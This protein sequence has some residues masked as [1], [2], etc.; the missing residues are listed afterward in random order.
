MRKLTK[1]WLILFVILITGNLF[2]SASSNIKVSIVPDV[3]EVV[4]G[5]EFNLKLNIK[6]PT[7]TNI[8]TFRLIVNF[9]A[10]KLEFSNIKSSYSLNDFKEYEDKGKLTIIYLTSEK[11]VNISANKLTTF[12]SLNFTAL[13][14]AELGNTKISAAIDGIGNYDV[15]EILADKISDATIKIVDKLNSN[16]TTTPTT[17]NPIINCNLKSIY[18]Q[19]YTIT[20]A[21]DPNITQY[22]VTVPSTVSSL[23]V[24]AVAED[25]SATV[26]VS[27]KKLYAAG[28]STD[29]NITVTGSDKKTKKIYKLT[30]V[31]EA[32]PVESNDE[33][34]SDNDAEDAVNASDK[35]AEDAVD[36]SD[37][38]KK[39][40][41]STGNSNSKSS[42]RSSSSLGSSSKSSS[43]LGN[44][45]KSNVSKSTNVSTNSD[46]Q[47]PANYSMNGYSNVSIVK[48]NFNF[49]LFFIISSVCV[50]VA[51]F[52]IKKK[53]DWRKRGVIEI[54][55]G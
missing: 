13:S 17:D 14:A 47:T 45:S 48:S 52:L 12:A 54:K 42:S 25:P 32:L 26:A 5:E 10:S 30:V 34:D 27:R 7:N 36:A 55:R 4:K 37:K 8:S 51:V 49:M 15:K 2:C 46:V 35:E 23:E 44:S 24:E 18:A 53:Y 20:P 22:Y 6:A 16:T 28:K 21:F 31:R 29:I 43:S 40:T 33:A 3:A 41:N 11:G 1:L 50:G 9:D 38:S 39:S 19:G